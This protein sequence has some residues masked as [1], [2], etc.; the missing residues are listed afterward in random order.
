MRIYWEKQG[1]MHVANLDWGVIDLKGRRVGHRLF[2]CGSAFGDIL[3]APHPTRDGQL[4]GAQPAASRK[5]FSTVDDAKQW[6][7]FWVKKT[8]K[9]IS[10][11]A[12]RQGWEIEF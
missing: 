7:E 1:D 4:F 12:E 3:L 5:R 6:A 10:K 8:D 2:I 9:R 11:Q